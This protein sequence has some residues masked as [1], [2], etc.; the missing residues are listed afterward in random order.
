MFFSL[1]VV[2]KYSSV[3]I[4]DVSQDDKDVFPELN[5]MTIPHDPGTINGVPNS[6]HWLWDGTVFSIC[7]MDSVYFWDSHTC[8]IIEVIRTHTNILNHVMA[9]KENNSNTFVAGTNNFDVVFYD[10]I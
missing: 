6:T 10:K 7:T 3:A 4:L 5:R 2:S 1:L 8:K 9:G